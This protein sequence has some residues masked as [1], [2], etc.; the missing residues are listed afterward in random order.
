[1]QME[2]ETLERWGQ[3]AYLQCVPRENILVI[4]RWRQAWQRGWDWM[5]TAEGFGRRAFASGLS[6]E[7]CAIKD[8]MLRAAWQRG[9]DKAKAG[10]E[11]DQPGKPSMNADPTGDNHARALASGRPYLGPHGDEEDRANP[12]IAALVRD[13]QD[14]GTDEAADD[15]ALRIQS[16]VS[17]T[18]DE[19]LDRLSLTPTPEQEAR[20]SDIARRHGG[21]AIAHYSALEGLMQ[22]AAGFASG[23]FVKGPHPDDVL[24]RSFPDGSVVFLSVKNPR[25]APPNVRPVTSG[26]LTD[27]VVLEALCAAAGVPT[28][29][30]RV[31]LRQCYR[32]GQMT[33]AQWQEHLKDDPGLE[34]EPVEAGGCAPPVAVQVVRPVHGGYPDAAPAEPVFRLRTPDP[35]FDPNAPVRVNGYLY[36]PAPRG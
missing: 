32:S 30:E 11:A 36:L 33:E 2:E 25:R 9:W 13:A 24:P 19:E 23:G 6:R 3:E 1:M 22:G 12:I 8:E 27:P 4:G 29:E 28:E 15:A 21:G 26:P 14:A 31:L 17:K 35:R 7:G 34:F 16:Y 10:I 18:G 5:N 20:A